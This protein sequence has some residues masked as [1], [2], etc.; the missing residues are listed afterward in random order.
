MLSPLVTTI[1]QRYNN[2]VMK[3]S[4]PHPPALPLSPFII[5]HTFSTVLSPY[6]LPSLCP[7]LQSSPSGLHNLCFGYQHLAWCLSATK[8]WRYSNLFTTWG[9]KHQAPLK[10]AVNP[11]MLQWRRSV[12]KECRS[13]ATNSCSDIKLWLWSRK[14]QIYPIDFFVGWIFD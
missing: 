3:A 8:E 5:L 2:G 14:E 13:W 6:S 4:P 7:D 11:Q 10:Q 12:A 9:A 1:N